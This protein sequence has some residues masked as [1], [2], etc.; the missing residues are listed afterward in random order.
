MD[1]LAEGNRISVGILTRLT[2]SMNGKEIRIWKEAVETCLKILT[3][4]KAEKTDFIGI[5]GLD[6]NA[7]NHETQ[8]LQI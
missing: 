2:V 8:F 6:S 3:R 4:Q 7:G 5:S 1:E